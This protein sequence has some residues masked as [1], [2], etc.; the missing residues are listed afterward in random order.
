MSEQW[1]PLSDSVG[2]LMGVYQLVGMIVGMGV[3]GLGGLE[4][5]HQGDLC[6]LLAWVVFLGP[7]VGSLAGAVWPLILIGWMLS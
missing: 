5:F 7:M 2:C 1:N 4:F 6:G 3:Y